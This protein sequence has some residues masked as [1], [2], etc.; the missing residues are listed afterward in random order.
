MKDN[1][2][3]IHVVPALFGSRGTFGGAERYC[4]E[5]CRAMA[6]RCRTTLVTFGTRPFDT[7]E[8][9]LEIHV[10]R[11]WL[12]LGRF[13]FDPVNPALLSHLGRADI[14]HFH[15]TH[16]MMASAALL[17]ARLAKK[18]FFST[19]LG[20]SG[21]S[22]HKWIDVDHWYTGHLHISEFSR[23]TA[24]H[25]TLTYAEVIGG[26]VD[27]EKFYPSKDS[28]LGDE[29]LY[30]GRLLPHKGINYLIEAVPD[31][32]KLTI[33]GRPFRHA[34]DYYELLKKLSSEKVVLFVDD[35]DEDTLIEYYRRALCIVLP[36]VHR[37][38]FG[39]FHSIPELLGQTV[40]EG[41]ACGLPAITTN[42]ASLPELVIDGVTGFIVPPNN[43]RALSE[44]IEWLKQNPTRAREMGLSARQH[45]LR[46][47]TW[48]RVVDRCFKAYGFEAGSARR[49]IETSQRPAHASK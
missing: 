36:S 48:D 26:G 39:E 29:V 1:P 15:Q 40:L 12:P 22:L 43:S 7:K 49:S 30:V 17:F 37:S 35:C 10:L 23:R 13:V 28:N 9:N 27:T 25:T 45:V 31:D 41:M 46:H 44:K 20:G 8:N 11:N 18:P 32:A 33:V 34:Q 21:V 3:V 2:H 47:F 4:L 16:T 5:L 24:G 14:C 38:V 42:V 19:D 6:R